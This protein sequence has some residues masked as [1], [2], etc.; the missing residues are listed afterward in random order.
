MAPCPCPGLARYEGKDTEHFFGRAE[1][2]GQV[3]AAVTGGGSSRLTDVFGA[4]GIGKSWLVNA[5]VL[6]ALQA[7][8]RACR[9]TPSWSGRSAG[10]DVGP[11]RLV[12]AGDQRPG[13]PFDPSARGQAA[14]QDSGCTRVRG[15]KGAE[16]ACAGAEG[17]LPQ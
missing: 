17:D 5:G 8:W 11:R 12:R 10:A 15:C 3:I 6:P 2:V 7:E 9:I 4:S 14:G 13:T 1:V 16:V